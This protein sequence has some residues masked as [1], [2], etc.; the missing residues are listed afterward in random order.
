LQAQ[1][2]KSKICHKTRRV[3]CVN[4]RRIVDVV[5]EEVD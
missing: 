1:T 2:K 4:K 5:F 3:R